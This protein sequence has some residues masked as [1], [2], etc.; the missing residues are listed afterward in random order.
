MDILSSK[1]PEMEEIFKNFKR[2]LPDNEEYH[3]RLETEIKL[4]IKNKFIKC[5]IQVV[6]ILEITKRIPHIIRGS[7]GSSLICY[8]LGI[9]SFDPIVCNISLAR[10]MN[11]KRK[12]MPDIDID[13]PYNKR[14]Y[15]FRKISEK[16][17]DKV[18]RISNHNMYKE[19]SALRKA[20]KDEGYNKFV[21][22][23][24]SLNKLFNGERE[25]IKNVKNKKE[26]LIGTFR[27][28]SLHCGGIVIFDEDIPDEYLVKEKQLKFNKDD[29][30]DNGLI[31]I[32]ILSN[33]GLAQLYNISDKPLYDYPNYDSGVTQVLI[34]G[35]NIGLTFA[36]SPGMRK[37][38]LKYRPRDIYGIAKCLALIRPSASHSYN[39]FKNSALIYDDDAIQ[40]IQDVLKCDEGTAD[41]YR[42]AFKK[43]NHAQILDF[44]RK[45]VKNPDKDNIVQNLKNL[46]YYS[47]CK[48]HAYSYAQLVFALAYQK[49]HNPK[50]FWVSTLNHCNSMYRTW[51]H[52]NEAKKSGIKL[53]LG[54]RPWK[55]VDDKLLSKSSLGIIST[56]KKPVEQYKKHG[57]WIN[58]EFID[59]MYYKETGNKIKFRGL[60]ATYRKYK[61]MYFITVGCSNDKMID[62]SVPGTINLYKK[63]VVEGSGV[64][65]GFIIKCYSCVGQ[66]L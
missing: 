40:Y 27:C 65:N 60:I 43:N 39:A 59:G 42:K 48:S 14:D 63:D 64:K 38:F 22:K 61:S 62:V 58:D 28:Y 57:Y 55:L 32:D 56:T 66:Y 52:M 31:K 1:Y 41:L 51:V 20:I 53:S 37:L 19:K 21:P 7:S 49:A 47:F 17:K 33:R 36:E 34:Y 25:T 4:I 30:E 24:F 11:N 44:R 13:F 12:D 5:F 29:V 9:T 50:Q 2:D 26:D 8:L 15:I 35:N 6:E 16:W 18:G 45:I 46:R 10:F 23:Y 3:E 54:K